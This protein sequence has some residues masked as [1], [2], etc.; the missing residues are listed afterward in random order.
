MLIQ[1]L[2]MV[3][4]RSYLV[5]MRYTPLISSCV[6]KVVHLWCVDPMHPGSHPMAWWYNPQFKS[7]ISSWV[8]T[9]CS[10]CEFSCFSKFTIW[11][12]NMSYISLTAIRTRG[13]TDFKLRFAWGATNQGDRGTV[14]SLS[15]GDVS[16]LCRRC[17]GNYTVNKKLRCTMDTK[18]LTIS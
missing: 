18:T 17:L 2:L 16:C 6:V 3:D 15:G 7:L 14:A 5:Y 1:L 8:R 13:P 10:S 4:R 12:C 9:I 11:W